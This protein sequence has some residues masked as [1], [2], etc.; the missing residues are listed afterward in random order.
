MAE[1]TNIPIQVTVN[2]TEGT[3]DST[4]YRG[5]WSQNKYPDSGGNGAAGVPK[6]DDYWI[7]DSVITISAVDYPVKSRFTALTNTPGQ[8]AGNWDIN[9][10]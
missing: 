7:T 6:V 4:K 5:T 2:I 10:G 9:Q 8:T 3:A 1:I